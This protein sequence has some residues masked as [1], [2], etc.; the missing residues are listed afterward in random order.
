MR[1]PLCACALYLVIMAAPALAQTSPAPSADTQVMAPPAWAFN[2]IACAPSLGPV[3][4]DKK[5]VP[6]LRVVGVQDPAIRELLGM[7]DTL[8]INAGS[9]VGL[10]PGQRFFVRRLIPA[11]S[12][13][14]P[15]PR[16]TIHTAGWVEILGVDTMVST[17]T[18]L[19]ACDGIL[20]DDYLEPYIAPMIAAR[21]LAGS[22]P[23]YDN[24]GRIVSGMEGIHTA[25]RGTAM[26]I[27]RGT[28]H[29]VAL[30]QRYIVFRD[31]RDQHIETAGRSKPFADMARNAP[32]V[33]VGEVLVISVRADD[34]TVQVVHSKDSINPG[35]LGAPIRELALDLGRSTGGNDA[36]FDGMRLKRR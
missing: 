25:A 33:E 7:G 19:H 1:N 31:K 13:T 21:P 16:A 15:T 17:A 10:Q 36:T 5:N 2:D 14:G 28:N 20:F 18:V 8:V 26:T 9:N 34:A 4:R 23:Q 12:V 30:G 29:G 32:L 3:K 11:V 35:D 27:D 6:Q 24:M 22:V